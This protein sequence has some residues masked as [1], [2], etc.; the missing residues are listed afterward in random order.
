MGGH[1][2]SE[3]LM[4][5]FLLEVFVR[6]LQIRHECFSQMAI[7]KANPASVFPKRRKRHMATINS[8]KF[9]NFADSWC[10]E[11]WSRS[12]YVRKKA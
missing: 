3:L 12:A 10:P 7:L 4:H 2:N 6:L 8:I 11:Y 9:T 5:F 1:K